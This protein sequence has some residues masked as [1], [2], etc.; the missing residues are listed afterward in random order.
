MSN[1]PEAIKFLNNIVPDG[2]KDTSKFTA[3]IIT[4][5]NDADGGGVGGNIYRLNDGGGGTVQRAL[6]IRKIKK[7]KGVGDGYK[8]PYYDSYVPNLPMKKKDRPIVRDSI[9]K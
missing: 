7:D 2:D 3:E 4:I 9:Q 8:W 1:D 5:P 6:R